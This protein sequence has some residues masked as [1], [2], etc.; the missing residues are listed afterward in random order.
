MIVS[1]LLD[2][3][4]ERGCDNIYLETTD[5][6]RPLYHSLGFRD[7]PDMMIYGTKN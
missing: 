5:E 7:M 6:G 3:A 2:I 4:V 1:H